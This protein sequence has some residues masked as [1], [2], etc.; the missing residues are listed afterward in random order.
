MRM[1][2]IFGSSILLAGCLSQLAPAVGPEQAPSDGAISLVDVSATCNTDSDPTRTVSFS[3]DLMSGVFLRG[4]CLSCHTG[5]GEGVQQSGFNLGSY[6]TLRAG[7]NHS[8]TNIVINF[9]PCSSILVLKI[10]TTPPFGKRMPYNGPPYLS[11]AD[12]QLV[13]DW[14][15]E[16]AR[17]N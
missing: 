17:D 9:A 14:I 10:D 15:A 7:G 12:I 4:K 2:I 8:G 16:G 3:A 13:R 6:T 1:K 11:S 5:G